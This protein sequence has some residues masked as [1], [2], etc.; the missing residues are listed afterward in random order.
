MAQRV[1]YQADDFF[2]QDDQLWHLARLK[3]KRLQQIAPRFHQLCIPKSFRMKIMHAIHDFSHY[4][5]LKC[6][7]TARQRFYW[8]SMA[9]EF[10]MFTQSCLVCQQIRNTAKP[11]FP[12]NLYS[13]F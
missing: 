10:A 11:H 6:Y 2:I 5:F 8:H 4:S 7:L 12:I 9:S 13:P 1:L 3:S